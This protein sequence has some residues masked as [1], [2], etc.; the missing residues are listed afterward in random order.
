MREKSSPEEVVD[1]QALLGLFSVVMV[2]DRNLSVVFASD[3]LHRHLGG[4][5][6]QPRLTE[7]FTL[8]RPRILKTYEEMLERLDTLYLLTSADGRFAVRGQVVRGTWDGSDCL[9]FCG[10]P[11]L[12]WI[13]SNCPEVKLGLKDFSHQDVQLDQLLYMATETNMVED[14]ERLNM[15]LRNAKE[16]LERAQAARN[17]FF[18]QMS[19][20]MRTPLNGVISALTLLQR[21][22]LQGQAAQLLDMARASSR[23]MLQTINYVLDIAKMEAADSESGAVDFHLAEVLESVIEI[24][25]PRAL[26]KN[27]DLRTHYNAVIPSAYHGDVDSLRQVLLNLL[28][29]A[30]KF[31]ES[32]G[33]NLDVDRARS[34]GMTLRIEVA[35]T[36]IGIPED[37]QATIFE[38]FR[39]VGAKRASAAETGSGLGLDIARR[40][41]SAM[42][43]AIG[44]ISSEGQGSRFWVELPLEPVET[45]ALDES[46]KP[47]EASP[48]AGFAGRVLLVDDNETNL[49]LMGMILEG[50]GLTVTTAISGE[51]AVA[52]VEQG[53]IDMVFMDISMPGIDGFEATRRIRRSKTAA[54]LPVIALTAYTGDEEKAKS[55]DAGMNDYLAKP[56]EH[57]ALVAVLGQ[58]LAARGSEDPAAQED[59]P[60]SPV[61]SAVDVGIVDELARQIGIDNLVTVVNKFSA[62]VASRWPSLE[63]ATTSAELAREAHTLVSTCGSFG[64]PGVAARLREIEAHAKSGGVVGDLE[65]LSGIA[66]ELQA[67]LDELHRLVAEKAAAAG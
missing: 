29:N 63:N 38:P 30:V 62:E 66:R 13:E 7:A 53:E 46:R 26:E 54:G 36:G 64:L 25:R 49:V 2:V 9:L 8:V 55:R 41:V 1:F 50:L 33:I 21:H 16:E 15:E 5:D 18:S 56:L 23:H 48:A 11:W 51:Q 40:S 32:G 58:Y 3:T 37:A 57:E 35:D 34:E 43:G 52:L 44:L 27:L 61:I 47:A 19:H 60:A 31:T 10:A 39:T 20:E 42:G 59:A 17:A 28:V 24:V 65:D 45:T 14:L 6:Q 67:G 22:Q 12:Y 4:L